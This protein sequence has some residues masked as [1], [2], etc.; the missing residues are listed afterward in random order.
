MGNTRKSAMKFAVILILFLALPGGV[1][2]DSREVL[3]LFRFDFGVQEE[4]TDNVDY[5]PSNTRDDWI[6]RVYGGFRLSTELAPE[7]AP[8]QVEQ[9]PMGRDPWGINLDYRLAYNYYANDTY[10]D[11]F[12]HDGRL[13]AWATIGRWVVV[14][15][16]DYLQ[17]SDEPLELQSEAG[18]PPLDYLPGSQRTRA[19]YT[20]NVLEPSA[21]YQFGKEDRLSLTYRNNYYNNES[22]VYEDSQEHRLTPRLDF[23]FN[24]RHGI[25]LEYAFDQGLFERSPDFEGHL[26]RARYTYRFSPQTS[27]FG[28]Y[29]FVRRDFD[30]P[31]TDYDAQN[32]S[33]GITHEF[34]PTTNGSLQIGYFWQNPQRGE[35]LDGISVNANLSTR[36]QY[37]D[38]SVSLRGGFRED[39]YTALNLGGSQ[40][41]GAYGSIKHRLTQWFSIGL[42]GSVVQ[43]E[44]TS[45]EKTLRWEARGNAT[46]QPLRWLSFT[47]EALHRTD[48]SNLEGSDVQENRAILRVNLTI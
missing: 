18:A 34:S 6:T 33:V 40:Y 9:K 20:R 11:Y 8:G 46:Y 24:I 42:L 26:G 25:S 5:S 29:A 37:T 45:G 3:S 28:E 48:D 10:D 15:L 36:T 32:P 19:K 35:A 44:Y 14:R 27:I 22:E 12:G 43:D 16:K 1:Y 41:Y 4:Y 7:R 23:W 31:G 38:F 47:L 13:D 39:Y 21:E 30:D 17:V 2:A